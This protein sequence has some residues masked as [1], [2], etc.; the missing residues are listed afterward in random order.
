MEK[1]RFVFQMIFGLVAVVGALFFFYGNALLLKLGIV[2]HGPAQWVEAYRWLWL[3]I[4]LV[5]FGL[6]F[7]RKPSGKAGWVIPLDVALVG[8][9]AVFGTAYVIPAQQ[10]PAPT[11]P[12]IVSAESINLKPEDW[13][14]GV[15]VGDEA[16]A[17]PWSMIQKEFVVND[18]INGEPIVVMYCI[19]CNSSLAFLSKHGG[20]ALRFGVAGEYAH[21]T[22]LHDDVTGSWWREDGTVIAGEL[23]G[24]ML[25]QL[26]AGLMEWSFWQELYPD[27][28]IAMNK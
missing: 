15:A 23:E 12:Q 28:Q 27:T 2:A 7:Y 8:A 9:V 4:G 1:S 16:K 19:S 11:S 13:V 22:I 26:P 17:Y 24:A 14:L 10:T 25:E 20:Q 21:E 18:I 3:V 6:I 5:S